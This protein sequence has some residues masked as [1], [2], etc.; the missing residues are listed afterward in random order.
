MS[1]KPYGKL[2]AE[3]RA[4]I[5]AFVQDQIDQGERNPRTLSRRVLDQFDVEWTVANLQQ[6]FR[7]MGVSLTRIE[8]DSDIAYSPPERR[9]TRAPSG[10][11]PGVAWD[12][13]EGELTSGPVDKPLD[14]EAW[15]ELLA[16]WDLDPTIYEVVEPVRF[17]AWDAAIGGGAVQRMYYYRATIRRRTSEHAGDTTEDVAKLIAE[18]PRKLPKHTEADGELAMIVNLA[19]WQTGKGEGGGTASLIERTTQ[20]IADVRQ[21]YKELRATGREIGAL[22]VAGLGDIIEQCTGNYPSQAFTTDLHRRGQTK[23][24]RRLILAAITA[25]APD[26]KRVVVLAVPGNHG[27]NRIDGKKFTTDGD[28]DDVALFETVAEICRASPALGHVSFVIPEDELTVVLDIAGTRVGFTHMHQVGGSGG[29]PQKKIKDW[30]A[31]QAFGQQPVG[32]AEILVSAHF[33]HFSVIEYGERRV[34]FQCPSNDGGSKWFADKTG[35]SSRSGTLTFLVGGGKIYQD[36]E[37]I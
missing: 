9:R 29:M 1:D 24:A 23:V 20:M 21:R 16:I 28:N 3:H 6:A 27:E 12:G 18:W 7:I 25:W 2:P 31:Q 4:Q 37:I 36:L 8:Q 33:H 17:R 22:Y 10:W 19:D 26:F 15:E 30:W 11:E 32:E 35:A 14:G 5:K 34:H 13:N